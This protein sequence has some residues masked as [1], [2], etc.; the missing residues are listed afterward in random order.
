LKELLKASKK[1]KAA[2]RTLM[3]HNILLPYMSPLECTKPIQNTTTQLYQRA[4]FSII[5]KILAKNGSRDLLSKALSRTCRTEVFS[6]K[7]YRG[8]LK[9]TKFSNRK[10]KHRPACFIEFTTERTNGIS[11][12]NIFKPYAQ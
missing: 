4:S 6:H 1:A 10:L 11:I 2:N 7:S 12:R 8:Q 3:T 5:L 9:S